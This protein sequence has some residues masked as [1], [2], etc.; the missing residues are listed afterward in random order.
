MSALAE[1]LVAGGCAVSGSDRSM[2]GPA[3][4]PLS[5]MGVELFPQDGSGL[6]P[7]KIFVYSTAIEEGNPDLLRAQE[8]GL[9]ILHRAEVIARL[10]AGKRVV[11]VSGTAGKTT[12]TALLGWVLTSAGVDPSVINGGILLN[13]RKGTRL[14][15]SRVGRSDLFIVEADE[16]DR[17]FLRLHPEWAIVSNLARDHFSYEDTVE[18]FREFAEQCREGIVAGPGVSEILA[19]DAARMDVRD[20]S[21]ESVSDGCA[22]VEGHDYSI[23]LPGLHNALNAGLV[24]TCCRALGVPVEA[25]ERG[26][27][28]FAGIHRRLEKVG[29]FAEMDVYDDYA[30]NSMKMKAA[31][32]TLQLRYA[33]VTVF[34]RPHGFG[35]LRMMFDDLRSMFATALRP[36]DKLFILPVFYAG[37]SADSS[38][39]SDQLAS[40][41]K[42]AGAP[43]DWVVDYASLS[44][45]VLDR[46]AEPGALL[47]MGARDP[48]ITEF[49]RGLVQ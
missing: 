37:G 1:F 42:E 35:P 29:R 13:W 10:A 38:L 41:L 46:A 32:E 25:V 28:S 5:E 34:W 20:V 16:S 30:H 22:R 6:S 31:M 40:A 2:D 26:V 4:R 3:I 21:D 8:L 43:V 19:L 39:D 11:A 9:D 14:G 49:L 7:G 47:G 23:P 17:S 24:I 48:Q 15:A 12:M 18:L 36:A 44:A 33:S 27:Q 45:V